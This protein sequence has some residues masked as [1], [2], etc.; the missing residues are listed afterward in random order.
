LR[1]ESTGQNLQAGGPRGPIRRYGIALDPASWII[2]AIPMA[3]LTARQTT[4]SLKTV[5]LWSKRSG[6]IRRTFEFKGF[7]GSIG[8]V[9]RVA[10]KAEKCDHH[11]DIDIRWNKV[12]LTLSTHSEGGITEKDFSLARQCDRIYSRRH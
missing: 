12:T 4:V 8:F 3:I 2:G 6:A 11:P 7:M 5:P 9:N 1:A 10:A